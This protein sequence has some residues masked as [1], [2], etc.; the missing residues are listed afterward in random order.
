M[1]QEL[2]RE[3]TLVKTL[4]ILLIVAIS[5]HLLGIFWQFFNNFSDI[6]IL[7]VISWLLSFVLEPVVE[8]ISSIFRVPKK[9]AT[10]ITYVL[11]LVGVI[12]IAFSFI[13]LVNRQIQTLSKV[14]PAFLDSA[15]PFMQ[16][17]SDSLTTGLNNLIYVAPSI[18]QFVVLMIVMLVISFY[19]IIDKDRI[20]REFFY[21][22]PKTWHEKMRFIQ[23]V[24]ETTFASFLRIQLIIGLLTGLATWIVLEILHVNFAAAIALLSGILGFL[25]L[26]GPI[27]AII[28]PLFVTFIIDPWLALIAFLIL[29]IIQQLIFNIFVPRAFGQ[30]FKMH[31]VIILVSSLVGFRLAGAM[32]AIFA[33]P[34]LGIAAVVLRDISHHFIKRDE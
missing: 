22:T 15:P 13:P 14:L 21:L 11:I 8:W 27:L 33:I 20:N 31:P 9:V 5:I 17:W 18:A 23:S 1:F 30:A 4:I 7:V 2:K 32:G 29:V 26:I 24:I 25:P 10:T 16:K 34:I 12:G 3:V 28:P 19:F 6:I